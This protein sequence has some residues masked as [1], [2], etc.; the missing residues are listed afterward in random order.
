MPDNTAPTTDPTPT[1]SPPSNKNRMHPAIP[2]VISIILIILLAVLSEYSKTIAAITTT[3]PT[4][5]PLAIWI[6]YIAEKGNREAITSFN[7]S[8]FVGL[9][10]TLGF[11][12]AAWVA[13][14]AGWGLIPIL[15]TGY[16]IWAVI[17]GIG[18]G[19]RQLFGT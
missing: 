10:A 6:V 17:L 13:A 19:L 5:I 11:T 4:K 2:V 15:A 14:K 16:V 8:M 7:G 12:L 9:I 1:A 18:L 3:M